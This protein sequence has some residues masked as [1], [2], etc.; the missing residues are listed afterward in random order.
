MK[1]KLLKP[2]PDLEV[3][4]I[5][6][7]RDDGGYYLESWSEVHAEF[8]DIFYRIF[9]RD[10]KDWYEKI[11]ET[12]KKIYDLKEGDFYWTLY[13]AWEIEYR[14]YYW[15]VWSKTAHNS[16][17]IKER[18]AKRHK[19]LRELATRQDKWLPKKWEEY[20]TYGIEGKLIRSKWCD[21]LDVMQYHLWIVFKDEQDYNKYMTEDAKDLLFNL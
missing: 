14:Q 13:E 4:T 9:H 5:I 19:L 12:P 15:W 18:E 1:Y 10:N 6:E 21:S 8:N 7:E 17:F 20:C 11:I 16:C 3:W 2:L